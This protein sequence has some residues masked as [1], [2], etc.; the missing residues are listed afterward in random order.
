MEPGEV[1]EQIRDTTEAEKPADGHFR[2][3]A[4]IGIGVLAMLL[5][6]AALGGNSAGREMINDNI[7]ASDTWAFFQA[8]TIRQTSQQ[9]AAVELEG[10]LASHPT[11]PPE[12]RA[13]LQQAIERAK[14]TVAR[15]ESE[16]DPKDPSDP[17]K[18]EG[19]KELRKRAQYFEHKRDRAAARL[20]NFEF[21]EALFQIAIVLGSVSIVASSRSLLSA[22]LALGLMATLFMLNGFFLFISLPGG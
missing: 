11:M 5:A 16:P 14:A 4:A 22:S 15:Y 10:L 12:A 17:R 20:P 9:L 1:A 7:L 6:I 3:R 21:A 18:G 8:K 19:R 2:R 13:S